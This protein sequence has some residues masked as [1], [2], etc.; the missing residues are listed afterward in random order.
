MTLHRASRLAEAEQLYRAVL[1]ADSDHFG[2]LLYLGV[3]ASEHG[4]LQDAERMIRHALTQ[5][6]DSSEAHNNLGIT[7]ARLGRRDEALAEYER[8][9]ALDPNSL[10]ARNNLG[11]ALHGLHRSEEAIVQF[12]QA[13]ALWPDVAELHSNLGN[14]LRAA[15]REQEAITSFRKALAIRPDSAETRNNFGVA[16]AAVAKYE[17]A[18]AEHRRAIA[19]NPRYFEAHNNLGNALAALKRYD[20]AV[21]HFESALA[22]R[23]EMAGTHNS[24]GNVLAAMRR[25]YDAERHYRKAIKLRP[26]FFEAYNNLGNALAASERPADAIPHYRKALEINSGYAEAYNNLG[27][28]F[29]ALDRYEDA[30]SCFRSALAINP[31]LTETYGCLGNALI[32][33]GRVD[34]GRQALE[35]AIALDPRQPEYYR[36]LGECRRFTPGDPHLTA[37][38]AL[39]QDLDSLTEDQRVVLHYVLAKAYGDVG[40]HDAAIPH[41]HEAN[42]LRRGQIDYDEAEILSLHRRVS[43]VFT[44]EL[45]ESKAGSGDPSAVPVFVVGMPRS[46]TTLIE[47]ML[48]SHPDVFGAGEI[49]ALPQAVE[50]VVGTNAPLFPEAIPS[51]SAEQLRDIGAH[52]VRNVTAR[53]PTAARITDKA[54]GNFV[55]LGLVRLALPNA[56]I[57]HIA[58]DAADV[59]FSC[60]S[61]LFA[62]ELLYTYDLG[63]LG[64]YY[65]SYETLM[66][67]WRRVLP[68]AAMLEVRYEDLV[69]DFELQA[70]RIVAYCGLD[71]DDRCLAFYKTKRAVRTASAAQVRQPVYRTSVGR[72]RPYETMLQPFFD[73]MPPASS[74]AALR[75][76]ANSGPRNSS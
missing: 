11:N 76:S 16:L 9:V 38:E 33:L 71:W 73:E 47:Q 4:H 14:A 22:I 36:G 41:L 8:A 55:Y 75:S 66:D 59:C 39:A 3:I 20:E 21:S 54:L 51:L 45:I 53:A 37:I 6:P 2:A 72:W 25:R 40:R 69:A 52:Y 64:R 5:K 13:L 7:L 67:H 26:D 1:K 46:G 74:A 31:K 19:L 63:E 34:E 18:V 32:T 24:Y 43:S 60:F 48:A 42:R 35:S 10:E 29:G 12:E 50:S 30:I 65:R 61:K 56:R 23:P 28:V 17:E 15:H 62:S 57:I 27:N 70:R 58:R 49:L 68:Q 44:S